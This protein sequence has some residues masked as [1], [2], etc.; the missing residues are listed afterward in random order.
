[1]KKIY[2]TLCVILISLSAQSQFSVSYHSSQLS[3][4]GVNYTYKSRL[5]NEFRT[6]TDI[7][8]ENAYFEFVSNYNFARK[9]EE[10][11]S[12]IGL[13]YYTLGD[14]GLVIPVGINIYPFERKSFGFL[15][16]VAYLSGEDIIRGSLGIRYR[17]IN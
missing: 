15:S 17:F 4:F 16:E 12:Y 11:D 14:G 7:N 5:I 13:G 6:S 2:L 10:Y 3:F 1:M 8:G 9:K